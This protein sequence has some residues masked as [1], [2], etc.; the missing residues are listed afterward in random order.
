MQTAKVHSLTLWFLP[1]DLVVNKFRSKPFDFSFSPSESIHLDTILPS[2]RAVQVHGVI[3]QRPPSLLEMSGLEVLGG[4]AASLQLLDVALKISQ[5]AS[6]FVKSLKNHQKDVQRL[7]HGK[8][9]N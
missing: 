4:V 1:K 2:N 5:K 3:A 7:R 8:I 6:N 9:L